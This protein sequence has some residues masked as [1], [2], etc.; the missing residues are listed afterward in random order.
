MRQLV[1][2]VIL[3]SALA[4][5]A[6]SAC[7]SPAGADS[8]TRYDFTGHTLYYCNNT[9]WVSLSSGSIPAGTIAGL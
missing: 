5:A 2:P 8:Q 6:Y 9:S 4:G 7:T 1:W 3:F